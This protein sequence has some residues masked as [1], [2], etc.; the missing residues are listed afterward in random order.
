MKIE[1]Y[2]YPDQFGDDAAPLLADLRRL[3]ESGQYILTPEVK[4]FEEAF[5]R[6]LGARFVRGVNSGTDALILA[7]LALG[8]GRGDEVIT[9][10]NTFHATVA[11]ILFAGATPVLVDACE[12]SFLMDATQV[13]DAVT[14]RTR[15]LLPVHLYGK[16]TPMVPLLELAKKSGLHVVEDACQAHGAKFDGRCAGTFGVVGCFSFHPSKNLAAA[17]DA[18]AVVTDR[19][20]LD[21]L[22]RRKRELGQSGQNHHVT[23]GLNTKLDALQACVLSWKL[24]RLDKWNACRRRVA[25]WYRER[26]H[27]LPLQFQSEDRRE[28][29]VY[30]LF[31]V[32]TERRDG[33][34]AHLRSAGIDAVVRYPEPIH[35]QEA[36]ADCGWKKGQFP[37]AERLAAELLCLPLRPDM[38]EG[39]VGYVAETVHSFF[40]VKS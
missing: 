18:G 7:L 5:A 40:Q 19:E 1:R 25:A 12:D 26:L 38:S 13:A 27:G 39:E 16:P 32:R 15:V 37:V 36:F 22:I 11:A 6:F 9:H 17:G 33:L 23:V 29:H 31:Q 34:L 3:L 24:P 10:A 4:R 8:V 35:L 2:N 20:D 14:H 28:E 21:E 30:H